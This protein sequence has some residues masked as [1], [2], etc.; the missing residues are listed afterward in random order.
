MHTA[1][2]VVEESVVD[3]VFQ[4]PQY[5]CRAT[6]VGFES[7]YGTSNGIGQVVSSC[8]EVVGREA[9]DAGNTLSESLK[10]IVW[11][12]YRKLDASGGS[13]E[14]FFQALLRIDRLGLEQRNTVRVGS[15]ESLNFREGDDNTKGEVNFI[16]IAPTEKKTPHRDPMKRFDTGADSNAYMHTF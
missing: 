15:D 6:R 2:S 12:F 13:V 4:D 10:C 16:R 9:F 7:S 11:F 3:L 14:G 5:P 8:L 1:E